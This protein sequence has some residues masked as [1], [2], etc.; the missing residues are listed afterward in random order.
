MVDQASMNPS[1]SGWGPYTERIWGGPRAS[2]APA[3]IL[4]AGEGGLR[5][6]ALLGAPT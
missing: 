6:G 4:K 1:T 2:I 3:S 5:N